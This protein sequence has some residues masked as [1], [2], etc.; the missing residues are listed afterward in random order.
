MLQ[1]IPT[2]IRPVIKIT[3]SKLLKV[4]MKIIPSQKLIRGKQ[5]LAAMLMVETNPASIHFVLREL[6]SLC[7]VLGH[8]KDRQ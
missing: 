6:A 8:D 2:N 4:R 7:F 5:I 3:L 1:A